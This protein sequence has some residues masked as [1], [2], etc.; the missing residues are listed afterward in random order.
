[1]PEDVGV[2][3]E[4][5][6]G[7]LIGALIGWWFQRPRWRQIGAMRRRSRRLRQATAEL[8]S[9]REI[10]EHYL[11]AGEPVPRAE[12]DRLERL[13]DD[14]DALLEQGSDVQ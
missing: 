1:M 12:R 8:T 5:I 9:A 7:V 2:P 14:L 3:V 10:V 13:T 6:A 4:L 11:Q